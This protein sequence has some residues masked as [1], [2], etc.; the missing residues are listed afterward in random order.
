MLLKLKDWPPEDDFAL[1]FPKRYAD[2]MKCIP[3][4]EYTTREG[5]YN[6]ASYMPDF[7]VRPDLGPKMYI[8]Y[9]SA[10]YPEYASTNLH[11]DMADAVNCIVYVGI[12]EDGTREEHINEG[13]KAVDEAG[14]DLA[15]KKRVR[16]KGTVIGALWHIFHP[17]DADK[18][19]DFLNKRALDK[20][21]KIEPHTD[22][23][24][25]QNVYLDGKLRKKLF[26]EYG[27]M[28]YAFPQCEG[29]T[30]FIP[31]GAPH[32][33][34]NINNCIKVALDFVSP[35]GLEWCF[36][37]SEEFR[38]LSDYHSNHE[39]KLQVKNILYHAV[40]GCVSLLEN[41]EMNNN[42]QTC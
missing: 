33:V 3:L 14:C 26:E 22:P 35:E 4:R 31:A 37:Q 10:L 8:A 11:L 21:K 30:V 36:L 2:L 32:Q 12:P 34:R 24:H 20:G 40:K 41:Y 39:D 7:F 19:R 5:R 28:G 25:D 27:V 18:I 1:Y 15:N 6:L 29:D 9:G 17:R 13:L 42:G 38:Q 23:I 16:Q